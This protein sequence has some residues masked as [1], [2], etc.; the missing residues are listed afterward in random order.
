MIR[1]KSE[2]VKDAIVKDYGSRGVDS[3]RHVDLEL[4]VIPL[5]AHFAF[6]SRAGVIGGDDLVEHKRVIES[7]RGGVVDGDGAVDSMPFAGE[8]NEDRFGNVERSVGID[9][10]DGIKFLNR[11]LARERGKRRDARNSEREQQQSGSATQNFHGGLLIPIRNYCAAP[12]P[13][14]TFGTSRSAGAVI[15]KN[16]RGLKLN[17]PAMMFVGNCWIFVFKSRTTAL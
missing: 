9:G 12:V 14:L 8:V 1:E 15:S 6:Q 11:E 5:A 4:L 13:K 17:M 2:A 16:S 10:D 3:V 7:L